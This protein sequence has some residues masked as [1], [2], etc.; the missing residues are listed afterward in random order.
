LPGT[1]VSGGWLVKGQMGASALIWRRAGEFVE[2][3][4]K[5]FSKVLDGAA[6]ADQ[7]LASLLLTKR[8]ETNQIAG[9]EES[10][11]LSIAKR[12]FQKYLTTTQKAD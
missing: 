5:N 11:L 10:K 7:N 4:E 8:S 2:C 12:N 3:F 1:A 9:G 6:K